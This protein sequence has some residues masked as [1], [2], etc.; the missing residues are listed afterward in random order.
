M[1][2]HS[3]QL[4]VVLP[5]LKEAGITQRIALGHIY[6]IKFLNNDLL[7]ICASGGTSLYDI[8]NWQRLW[9]IDSPAKCGTISDD[10]TTLALGWGQKIYIWD[11]R[12]RQLLRQLQIQTDDD[13]TITCI[14]ISS[15]GQFL[16][17]GDNKGTVRF[18]NL[19]S[20]TETP[21]IQLSYSEE[22]LEVVSV[23]IASHGKFLAATFIDIGDVT[24]WEVASATQ[25]KIM[26]GETDFPSNSVFSSPDGRLIVCGSNA[27]HIWDMVAGT[28]SKFLD[29]WHNNAAISS[30]SRLLAADNQIWELASQRNI[31]T[32]PGHPNYIGSIAFSPNSEFLAASSYDR[33]NILEIP[34]GKTMTVLETQTNFFIKK[35]AFSSDG[36][37][38][39]IVSRNQVQLWNIL[40]GEKIETIVSDMEWVQTVASNSDD[41]CFVFGSSL[42]SDGNFN[43]ICL[44]GNRSETYI[45]I[46]RNSCPKIIAIS[47]DLKLV[48]FINSEHHLNLWEIASKQVVKSFWGHTDYIQSVVFSSDGKFMASGSDDG[49][50]RLWDIASEKEIKI[51]E[52][53]INCISNVVISNNGKFLIFSSCEQVHLWNM[54]SQD[55][56]TV[57]EGHNNPVESL[58]ISPDSQF[59][60]S[61]DRDGIV[62]LWDTKSAKEIKALAGHTDTVMAIAF[63]PDSKLI[64][65]GSEDGTVRLWQI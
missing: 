49:T 17:C 15:Q 2:T 7:I 13:I 38:L 55:E 50:V 22:E 53:R 48:A 1:Y 65:T 45:Q 63:S 14:A 16:A 3:N 39:T 11:L 29:S 5:S 30:D 31:V 20:T 60:A 26:A 43:Q 21:A 52:V 4:Q 61:G 64:A 6:K 44:W 32:L 18:W 34:S 47:P 19:A 36:K 10:G 12:Q 24:V 27:L 59:L 9:D 25:V 37:F 51:L 33:V 23:A 54:V 40:S 42:I 35:V 8:N 62:K 28:E 58:A 46:P 57:L 41:Y 56:V